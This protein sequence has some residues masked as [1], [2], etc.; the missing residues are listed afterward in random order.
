[1]TIPKTE[2]RSNI[3]VIRDTIRVLISLLTGPTLKFYHKI[4]EGSGA[5]LTSTHLLSKLKQLD[6]HEIYYLCLK[7]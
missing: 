7:D 3:K 2:I 4:T 1:V 5:D 6:Y